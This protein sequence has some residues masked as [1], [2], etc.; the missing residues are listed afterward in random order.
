MK[1]RIYISGCIRKGEDYNK[2]FSKSQE[3]LQKQGYFVVNSGLLGY[4]MPEDVTEEY[5]KICFTLIDMCNSIYMLNGWE[6]SCGANREYGYALAKDKT[7]IFEQAEISC[8]L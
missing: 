3:K 8:S 1:E 6:K 2:Q 5:M 4:I 7:V